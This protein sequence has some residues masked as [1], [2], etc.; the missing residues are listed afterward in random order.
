MKILSILGI[1]T[2]LVSHVAVAQDH[3]GHDMSMT[4]HKKMGALVPAKIMGDHV[5]M[6]GKAMLSYAYM[7]MDMDGYR[8]GVNSKSINDVFADGYTMAARDMKMEMHMFAGMV[9]ITNK[10]TA[11]VMLP[12][13]KKTMR[14]QTA[15]G[16]TL[17][18]KSQSVGDI[19]AFAFKGMGKYI[20]GEVVAG[21]GV[22]LPT[23]SI[24]ERDANLMGAI[25]QLPYRMQTGSGT[26]DLMPQVTWQKKGMSSSLGVQA[27]AVF[28]TGLNDR[29]YRLGDEAELSAWYGKSF[30]DALSSTFRV[31]GQYNANIRGEDTALNPA[32]TP[33]ADANLHS[34]TRVNVALGMDYHPARLKGWSI[35][36]E[37]ELPVYQNLK[38][39]QMGRASGVLLRL[40]KAF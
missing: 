18:T 38:G 24:D 19:K 31:T 30:N 14:M 6:K 25:V 5:M 40:R 35:T 37:V 12:Y 2:I 28:R 1:S 36:G 8:Q 39:P 7:D 4:G 34:G 27:K 26:Y 17:T 3:S 20:G 15:A 22:S 29:G 10:V 23:G 21:V 11:M 32:M 16:A 9:G 13:V 33:A